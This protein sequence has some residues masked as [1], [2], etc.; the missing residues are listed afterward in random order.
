MLNMFSPKFRLGYC[1]PLLEVRDES[2]PP[3]IQSPCGCWKG[4]LVTAERDW[5]ARLTRYSYLWW[6]KAMWR[7]SHRHLVIYVT[8]LQ[9]MRSTHS[10]YPRPL[11]RCSHGESVALINATL[12]CASYSYLCWH[13]AMWRKSRRRLVIYM[14]RD[15]SRRDRLMLGLLLCVCVT[16]TLALR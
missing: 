16:L 15:C 9:Q 7:K 8:W 12:R 10:D 4:A 2:S 3:F 5:G 6:H 13:K 11:P 14:S 1:S